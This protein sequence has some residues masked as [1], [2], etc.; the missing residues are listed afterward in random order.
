[1]NVSLSHSA[2]TWSADL[3]YTLSLTFN[4]DFPPYFISSITALATPAL[5]AKC[6]SSGWF[7]SKT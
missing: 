3:L 5:L 4:S 2:A 6:E 7:S 1:M